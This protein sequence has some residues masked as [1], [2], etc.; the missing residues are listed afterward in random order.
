MFKCFTSR[1]S[2]IALYIEA[3][4]PTDL[5]KKDTVEFSYDLAMQHNLADTM[6]GKIVYLLSFLAIVLCLQCLIFSFYFNG[7]LWKIGVFK[8]FIAKP[9]R[10]TSL[11]KIFRF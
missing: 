9:P 2:Q 10:Y 3:D 1:K 6:E 8:S 11:V 4:P 7:I 5:L